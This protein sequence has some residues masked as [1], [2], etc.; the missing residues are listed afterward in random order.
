MAD[1]RG[2]ATVVRQLI[3][4]QGIVGGLPSPTGIEMNVVPSGR[5]RARAWR[6]QRQDSNASPSIHVVAQNMGNVASESSNQI[7]LPHSNGD[8]AA[9]MVLAAAPQ[10]SS[11]V[12][13]LST[14]STTAVIVGEPGSSRR[15]RPSESPT[16][17][18]TRRRPQ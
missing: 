14:S 6:Q 16:I 13:Q 12:E 10:Q 15:S 3:Q 4:N 5:Q 11:S 7:Q 8:N 1:T 17:R 18:R 2:I 9:Q